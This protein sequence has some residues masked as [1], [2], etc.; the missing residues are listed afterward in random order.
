MSSNVC[1]KPLTCQ[2]NR[3]SFTER[4]VELG[5]T[6]ETDEN[7]ISPNR[8]L[9]PKSSD[10]KNSEGAK[11]TAPTKKTGETCTKDEECP[12]TDKCDETTK[13]C[14][15]KTVAPPSAT[16]IAAAVSCDRDTKRGIL[17]AGVSNRCMNCGE[18]NMCDI[19][20]VAIGVGKWIV[21]LIGLVAVFFI[22]YAAFLY[23]TSM[24]NPE[25]AKAAKSSVTAAIVGLIIV[26]SSWALVNTITVAFGATNI[27][28]WYNP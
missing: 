18:C 2:L 14:T 10:P 6:C 22:A 1:T 25:K 3:C 15:V 8:C 11:C 20:N 19:M 28:K 21:S 12:A 17:T 9:V 24:G 5:G 16:S 27:G 7:C 26:F 13:K 23:I 4:S